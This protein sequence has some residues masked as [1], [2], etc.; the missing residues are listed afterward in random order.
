ME[1]T[2]VV[3]QE[4][5]SVKT[6]TSMKQRILNSFIVKGTFAYGSDVWTLTIGMYERKACCNE[7]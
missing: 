6:N 2:C 3:K 7:Y 5:K 1:K 4:D